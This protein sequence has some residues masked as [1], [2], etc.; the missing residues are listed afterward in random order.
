MK[1]TINFGLEQLLGVFKAHLPEG[2]V[3]KQV[4]APG[5]PLE[6]AVETEGKHRGKVLRYLSKSD[7]FSREEQLPTQPASQST[8]S[9]TKPEPPAKPSKPDNSSKGAEA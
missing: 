4:S 3:V 6:F 7:S 8:G 9:T 2:T 5:A 1:I